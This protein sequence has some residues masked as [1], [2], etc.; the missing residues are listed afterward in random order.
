MRSRNIE[1]VVI[2]CVPVRTPPVDPDAAGEQADDV[3]VT[4][5][6]LRDAAERVLSDAKRRGRRG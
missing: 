2:G 1:S 6:V 3:P 5:E 4:P